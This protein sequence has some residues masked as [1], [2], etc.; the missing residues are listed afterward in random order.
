MNTMFD[1]IGSTLVYGLLTVALI[2]VSANLTTSSVETKSAFHSEQNLL[3]LYNFFEYDFLKIGFGKTNP[4]FKTGACDSLKIS[5]Y[6]DYDENGKMDSIMYYMDNF[7]TAN[8]G[9]ITN[10]VKQRPIFRKL[11]TEDPIEMHLNIVSFTFSYLDANSNLLPYD[12]LKTV[13]GVN[14][15]RGIK[16]RYLVED[17][18]QVKEPP[19][20]VFIEKTYYPKNLLF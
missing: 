2:N 9:T 17:S 8:R 11:N 10:T 4:K 7:Q 13:T 5:W 14:K 20:R 6:S 16:V 3:T 12:S 18:Y 19:Q 15:I 1:I